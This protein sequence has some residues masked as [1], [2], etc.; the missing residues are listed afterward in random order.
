MSKITGF[1]GV[2]SGETISAILKTFAA[3]TI[4]NCNNKIPAQKNS[5]HLNL[6]CNTAF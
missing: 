5:F 3:L 1:F 6:F 2:L 4:I